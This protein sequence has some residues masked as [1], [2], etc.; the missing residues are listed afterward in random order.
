MFG[1][2]LRSGFRSSIKTGTPARL[3]RV[4][5]PLAATTVLADGIWTYFTRPEAIYKDGWYYFGWCNSIGQ[6][7]VT[8]CQVVAG[9]VT[10]LESVTLATLGEVDDHD[11]ASVMFTPS[12]ALVAF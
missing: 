10:S 11:N 5:V 9:S 12:G 8:R 3:G 1:R 6:A 2:A 4:T 7:G